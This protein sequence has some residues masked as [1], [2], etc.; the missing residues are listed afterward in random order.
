MIK[1]IS[2][3]PRLQLC[4]MISNLDE[5]KAKFDFLEPSGCIRI[6]KNATNITKNVAI[7]HI[8]QNTYAK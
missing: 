8:S 4:Q 3:N 6:V 1:W 7:T 2:S 5:T